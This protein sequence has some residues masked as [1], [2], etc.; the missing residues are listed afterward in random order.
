MVSKKIKTILLLLL[1]FTGVLASLW[2]LARKIQ[3]PIKVDEAFRKNAPGKFLDMKEGKTHYF[4]TGP[5]TGKLVIF[6]HGGS[7][8]GAYVWSKNYPNLNNAGYKT[9][10]Y[11]LY[12]RGF[13]DRPNEAHTLPLFYQQLATLIDT[14]ATD[15]KVVLVALSMGAM[16]AI[17]YASKHPEKIRKIILIDPAALNP[18]FNNMI[19]NTAILNRLFVTFYWHPKAV[20]K[21]MNEFYLPNL[22]PEYRNKLDYF[23]KVEGLE[24]TNLSTWLHILSGNVRKQLELIKVQQTPVSLIYGKQDPYF[25]QKLTQEYMNIFQNISIFPIDSAGHVSNAERPEEVNKILL[26]ELAK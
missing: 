9:C 26:E 15:E 11:D 24:E 7:Q 5:D 19:I 8:V 20:D 2:I 17:D 23:S 18:P 4:V 6:V 10:M 14:V 12:G 22:L 1:V 21:Q 3:E 25:S 13:S 16:P